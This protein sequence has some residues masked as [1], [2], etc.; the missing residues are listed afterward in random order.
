MQRQLFD[1]AQIEESIGDIYRALAARDGMDT[2]L[3]ALWR[4]LARDEDAHA[5]QLRFAGRLSGENI[6]REDN[7]VFEGL[8]ELRQTLGRIKEEV[9]KASLSQQ[10]ALQVTVKL[11]EDFCRLHLGA[12]AEISDPKMREMF[13]A[14]ARSDREHVARLQQYLKEK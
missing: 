6:M 11:E 1:C 12:V 10:R 2:E 5:E 7:A 8:G 4:E 14:L 3:R 9:A 13:Q